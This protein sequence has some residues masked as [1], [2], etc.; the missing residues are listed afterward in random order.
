[1]HSL[2]L[3]QGRL[4][5]LARRRHLPTHEVDLGYLVHCALGE[6]FG[7]GAP[8]PF[9]V[10]DDRGPFV[11]VFG[12]AAQ[13]QEALA[14]DA[15]TFAEPAVHA[16]CEAGTHASKALPP[17]ETGQKLGYEVRALAVVRLGR[18]ATK[19]EPG[20]E[21]DAFLAAV[22]KVGPDVKVD[23]EAVYRDWFRAQLDRHAGARVS[24]SGVQVAAIERVRLTRRTQAAEG[25][26]AHRTEQP[27]VTFRGTLEV[28][29]PAAFRALLA[30]GIG[31]HRSF[32][33]GMLTLR[34]PG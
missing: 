33:F 23:R 24:E 4:F 16:I 12:Y 30:R 31:R 10:V 2:R 34:R 13:S 6:L 32:G 7:T 8:K 18:G 5:E 11:K 25:R 3:H 9:L 26:E 22:S 17:F 28:T 15:A 19:R 14:R 20:S 21:A 27:A 29:D 1:M